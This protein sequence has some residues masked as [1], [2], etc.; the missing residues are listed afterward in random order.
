MLEVALE[1]GEGPAAHVHGREHEVWYV[2]DGEFRFLLGDTLVDVP[3]GGLAFGP[4][5]TPHTFQN[6][7][8]QTGRL[9]VVTAPSGL[10]DFFLTYDR[11]ASGQGDA[12]ALQ[13]AAEA[14]GL[15]FVGPPL[16]AR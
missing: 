8:T 11:E 4:I 9:L 2:L 12:V 13:S 15:T 3:I 10:E 16:A 5:G 1:P 14:S 6:I 7:G